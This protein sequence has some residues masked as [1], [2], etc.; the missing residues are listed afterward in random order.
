MLGRAMRLRPWHVIVVGGGCTGLAT[1]LDAAARGYRT[2]LVE[3]GDFAGG[4][5]SR[6]TKLV[7]G[8]VRYLR[9]GQVQ[10]VRSA[11]RERRRLWRN[12]PHLVDNLPLIVPAYRWWER[13][14]YGLGLKVYD[15]L[16]GRRGLG[17]SRILGKRACRGLVS[18]LDGQGL[19]GGVLYHDGQF[20][21]A[22]LGWTLARTAA[23][24]GAVTVNYVEAVDLIEARGMVKGV[25]LRDVT[26]GREWVAFG[27]VVVNAAGPFADSLRRMDE[28]GE[29][30][31]VVLSRGA[32]IV[33]SS[34][35]LPGDSAVLVPSTDDGR[36]LFAIPWHGHVVIGT[37]DVRVESPERDPAPSEEEI[38]YL[39]DHAG[40][41]LTRPIGRSDILSA[42]AGLRALAGTGSQDTTAAISRDHSVSVSRRGLVTVAGGK[43]TT[44]RKVAQDTVDIAA[45]VGGLSP[46]PSVTAT[47]RL[48]GFSR[49]REV[50]DPWRVYGTDA[51][52]IREI[53]AHSPQLARLMHPSLPYR[54]SQA[55]WAARSEMAV[56]LEDVLA[57][58]TRALFLNARAA[59]AAAPDVAAVM[60]AELGRSDDW[61]DEEVRSFT[62]IAKRYVPS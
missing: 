30:P 55:A 38:D 14:W 37:T 59:L 34:A 3:Q 7:H 23:N 54:L 62:T 50:L 18:T 20:D 44:C 5:S 48:H 41:Y 16:A 51:A 17:R 36:V 1:A 52:G 35:F 21:D 40:R 29:G 42:W 53:E 19:R 24:I 25:K 47:L 57:R 31:P 43:W 13:P 33:V 22:R 15:A 45:D 6:S 12:A 4:T 9:Q 39:I 46:T 56:R 2:L 32:H 27:A 10:L 8:G 11:L 61:A 49:R 58:R 26:G 60:A 28:P